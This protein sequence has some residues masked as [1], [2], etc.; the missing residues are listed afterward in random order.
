MGIQMERIECCT[1]PNEKDICTCSINKA[2]DIVSKKWTV[3]IVKLLDKYGKLRYNEIK[4]RLNSISP[5]SLSD[6]LK[7]LE[8]A[9]LIKKI[10]FQEIPVKVEYELS[11]KGKE[12]INSIR[13]LIEWASK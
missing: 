12:L 9:S 1:T 6:Q 5:K 13:P 7:N 10:V 4:K 3:L 2:L 8:N 11:D